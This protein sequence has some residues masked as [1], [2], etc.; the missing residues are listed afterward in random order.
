MGG[1][2]D[3]ERLRRTPYDDLRDPRQQLV[4]LLQV[5]ASG[6][7]VYAVDV[8]AGEWEHSIL[9]V[10]RDEYLHLCVFISGFFTLVLQEKVSPTVLGGHRT[11][12]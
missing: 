5:G 11:R 3:E 8:H 12:T 9:V 1:H 7:S 10:A 4:K 6:R 2:S